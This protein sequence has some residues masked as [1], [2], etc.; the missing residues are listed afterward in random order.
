[1]K[2]AQPNSGRNQTLRPPKAR[3]EL[4]PRPGRGNFPHSRE[5]MT[6]AMINSAFC[7][8]SLINTIF[9]LS[10]QA[11][12]SFCVHPAGKSGPAWRDAEFIY[13]EEAGRGGS[14]KNP[15]ELLTVVG[16]ECDWLPREVNLIFSRTAGR[17]CSDQEE[18]RRRLSQD[19]C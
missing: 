4:P 13:E 18:A 19:V 12:G 16:D 15:S 11:D 14:D 10:P 17:S 7:S 8:A 1:M 3:Q 9:V 5:Q 2:A 6:P